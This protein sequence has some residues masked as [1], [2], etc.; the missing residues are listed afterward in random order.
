MD[1]LSRETCSGSIR[2]ATHSGRDLPDE[3]VERLVGTPPRGYKIER[4]DRLFL[5]AAKPVA[6]LRRNYAGV[7]LFAVP[8]LVASFS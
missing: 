6:N 4:V 8:L 3:L 7:K 1:R 2:S 5:L